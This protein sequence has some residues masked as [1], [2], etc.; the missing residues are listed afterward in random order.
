MQGPPTINLRGGTHPVRPAN[1]SNCITMHRSVPFRSSGPSI[2]LVGGGME[3]VEGR[4]GTRKIAS[5]L[6]GEARALE[7]YGQPAE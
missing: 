6:S 5:S 3:S 2:M 1:S 4:G 7:F